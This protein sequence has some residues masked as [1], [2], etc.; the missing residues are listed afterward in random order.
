M[1]VVTT[2]A[3]SGFLFMGVFGKYGDHFGNLKVIKIAGWGIALLPCLWLVSQNLIYVAVVQFFAGAVWGGF[4][5]LILNFMMEAVS[6]E[7]RIRCIS[8]FN[9][10]NSVAVLTGA[11][12]G[13]RLFHHL[14]A[15]RGYSY[16]S[17]FLLSCVLRMTVMLFVAP[18]VREVRK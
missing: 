18:L 12:V 16:L 4:N 17:L 3:F 11:F 5:L 13:S 14:P 2:A 8:Y 7:K 1:V 9:V 6:P 15:L 10:M